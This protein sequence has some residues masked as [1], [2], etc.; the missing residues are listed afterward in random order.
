MATSR[1]QQAHQRQVDRIAAEAADRI[2]ANSPVKE[3]VIVTVDEVPLSDG[4]DATSAGSQG[5]SAL[6]AVMSPFSPTHLADTA[7]G[8]MVA[9]IDF[10]Q[11]VFAAQLRFAASMANAVRPDVR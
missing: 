8:L 9:S 10:T 3:E 5:A 1:T 7:A 6:D 4:V 11:R 2:A